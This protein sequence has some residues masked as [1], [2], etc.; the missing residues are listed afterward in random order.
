[1]N[2]RSVLAM[3]LATGASCA[4]QLTGCARTTSGRLTS[5][6]T[7]QQPGPHPEIEEATIPEL[8][9]KLQ[10]RELTSVDLVDRYLARI[11]ALDRSGPS[12]RSVLELDPEARSVAAKLDEERLARGPR[13]PLHG[14]PML[15]KDNIDT[16]GRTRTTAGSLA[17]VGTPPTHDAEIVARLRRAGAVLLGKANLSEWANIRS[18][19][20]TSGW[21]ATGGLTRNPYALDRNPSGSSS[22][23][24]V[25]MSAN[26]A[27]FA[28]GTETDGSIVSPSSISGIV[29]LKPTVGLVSRSGIV[30]ISHSQDTAGPMTRSVAD[31]AIVLG[32]LAGADP[33][34]TATA[35][36]GGRSMPD[37]AASL[38]TDGA[39]GKR[40]GVVRIFKD[41][42][43]A[44]IAVFDAAVEELRRLDAVVIDPVDIGPVSKLGDAELEVMLYELKAGMA[45]YLAT[46][47]GIAVKNLDDLV[48]FNRDHAAE[49]LRY[50]GQDLFEQA[51]KKGGLD[52]PG[53]LEAAA[54]C[55]R[56]SRD[57]GIDPALRNHRLD[58]LVAP[59]GGPAWLTDL[60]NGDG[61]SGSSA[62]PAAIAGYP[63]ITV[64]AGSVQ[65]LPVGI[66]FFGAAF[67]EPVLLSLAYAYEQRT[68]HRFKPRYLPTVLGL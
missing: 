9:E 5:P 46:R 35:I 41:I 52:S 53:Y 62:S 68:R 25:A 7:P 16:V 13:S 2:R 17:L 21:S 55:R 59:T 19:R 34:D 8:A 39:R 45:A 15:V 24:A 61:F 50:F 67:S 3:G 37:Y 47:P 11:G 12:L 20:S 33:R 65:G 10:R 6:S 22:G 4:A 64:P 27:S 42:P 36:L 58:A 23:S 44:A 49:E 56:V 40:I 18:L 54:M 43:R 28:I 48:R 66:S 1:M 31:A 60:V 26:L 38:R 14:I 29:G 30:P 51:A 63:N 57:E 32:I